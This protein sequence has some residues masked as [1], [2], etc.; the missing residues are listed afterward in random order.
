MLENSQPNR[1]ALFT[2]LITQKRFFYSKFVRVT[3]SAEIWI[4]YGG[5]RYSLAVHVVDQRDEWKFKSAWYH[6]RLWYH[7]GFSGAISCSF[8]VQH[9]IKGQCT[10][11]SKYSND[12]KESIIIKSDNQPDNSMISL[13]DAEYPFESAHFRSRK[14][15][16]AP[17]PNSLNFH[18]ELSLLIPIATDAIFSK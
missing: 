11:D 13:F 1:T 15:S 10:P 2:F 16:A 5:F 7:I 6:T 8:L 9:I 18:N 17:F 3:A 14:S 4:R 12:N